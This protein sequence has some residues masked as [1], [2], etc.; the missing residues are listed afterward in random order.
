MTDIDALL[1]LW[2]ARH[3]EA[4]HGGPM[5]PHHDHCLGCG[6]SNPHGLQ[7]QVASR[8]DTV[9]ASH[10]FDERHVGAPGIAH[11]GAVAAL[12]DDL[13]GFLLFKAGGPAVTRRLE[14]DYIAPALLGVAYTITG[15]IKSLQGRSLRLQAQM[16]DAT[17]AAVASAKAVFVMVDLSHFRNAAHPAGPSATSAD[18]GEPSS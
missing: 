7:L 11:G 14:V 16:E 3:L 5:P 9:V 4:K 6:P 17:G 2:E 10:V 18:D 13:F 1:E 15:R 8:G 12:F